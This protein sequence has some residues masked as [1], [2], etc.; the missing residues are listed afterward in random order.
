MHLLA[1]LLLAAPAPPPA[2]VPPPA[3]VY[4]TTRGTTGVSFFLPGGG[5]S[6][7]VGATYFLAN[8][9]AVRFDL[10]IAASLTPSGAGFVLFSAN[11]GLRLYQLKHDRVAVFL[12]P[13]AGFGR[14]NS[15]ATTASAA[16]FLR[17]GGG[18]GVEYFFTNHF[19]AGAILELAFKIANI[20]GSTGPIYT[21]L[22][23]DT[24]GLTANFYF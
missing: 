18:V 10:G 20:A 7:L 14:E 1:L 6:R 2:V 15:P 3:D 9:T 17:L 23:T 21:S 12:Q 13:E 11:A 5:D 8:D 19:S 24:S 4:P 22:T 16:L